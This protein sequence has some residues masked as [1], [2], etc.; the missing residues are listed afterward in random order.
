MRDHRNIRRVQKEDFRVNIPQPFDRAEEFVEQAFKRINCRGERIIR[1][2]FDRCTFSRC[3]MAEIIFEGCT[4]RE[5]TF[6]DCTLRL[7]KIPGSRFI[8]AKFEKCD[9]TYVNW[10]DGVWPKIGLSD[11]LAFV[12]CDTS[13]STFIGLAL[14]KLVMTKCTAHDVDF[15]EADLTQAVC[16]ETDFA[17]SRFLNTNLTEADFT[18]ALG[19]AISPLANRIKKAK[20]SIPQALSLLAAF[21]IVIVDYD[22]E[23]AP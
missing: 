8:N 3:S 18:R 1:K 11:G 15:S 17:D 23:Q 9:V 5:C 14:K 4:F 10:T 7:V 16:T 12:E 22:A 20:F 21:E 6:T 13:Y 2:T 19:Y